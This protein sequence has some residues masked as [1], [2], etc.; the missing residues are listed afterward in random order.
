MTLEEIEKFRLESMEHHFAWMEIKNKPEL[1]KTHMWRIMDE[2][3]L[4]AKQTVVGLL[5]VEKIEEWDVKKEFEMC[6]SVVSD[7]FILVNLGEQKKAI[8][9]LTVVE[10]DDSYFGRRPTKFMEDAV[11]TETE[12]INL[13]GLSELIDS[14]LDQE[15]RS[16]ILDRM[17]IQLVVRTE[18]HC[19]INEMFHEA[20][21]RSFPILSPLKQRHP[22][23]LYLKG[24]IILGAICLVLALL[25]SNLDG[26]SGFWIPVSIG[27]IGTI[28]ALTVAFGLP[29]A[30][31]EHY[32]AKKDVMKMFSL[33]ARAYSTVFSEWKV[34]IFHV[35]STLLEASK[36]DVLYPTN[37]FVLLE[38]I[39]RRRSVL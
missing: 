38:D 22:A 26:S 25:S 23:L 6:S 34:S 37:V 5:E 16:D 15:Y 31:S 21:L 7:L 36:A 1:M 24:L 2:L 10:R 33:M 17:L 12:A 30:I 3:T 28:L 14:Y 27:I 32:L 39:K 19:F 29:R 8:Q 18:A 13:R 4:D 35:K 11:I 20:K 9:S